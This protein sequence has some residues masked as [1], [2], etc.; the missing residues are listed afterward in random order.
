[1]DSE[2]VTVV[3]VETIENNIEIKK[4]N[5][6]IIDDIS[7]DS[8]FVTVVTVGENEKSL[9]ETVLVYR[10]P[11]ERLGFGL[12]FQGGTKTYE[13][14]ERLYI[15]SC[16]KDSPASNAIASWGN[17]KEGDEI[18]EIDS[19][20]VTK[21][22]RLECVKCLKEG[23]VAMKFIVRN[24]DFLFDEKTDEKI[25]RPA[26]P[27]VPPRKLNGN[28]KI[29]QHEVTVNKLK[30]EFTPPPEAEVYTNLFDENNFGDE[31][32]ETGSTIS[33]VTASTQITNENQQQLNNILKTFTQLEKEFTTESG[34]LTEKLNLVNK[35]YENVEIN[36][37]LESKLYENVEIVAGP[38]KP[39]PRQI[40]KIESK[41]E[42]IISNP[43]TNLN[44]NYK[45]IENWL[46]DQD[47]TD[48]IHECNVLIDENGNEF[49]DELDKT[50]IQLIN[51]E[52]DKNK[53]CDEISI[54]NPWN[55]ANFN[56]NSSDEGECEKGENLGPPEILD[57]PAPSE[58]YF[59]F[60]WSTSLL[61]TIG[62]V[63]EE[64]S[65]IEPNSG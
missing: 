41:L 14:V 10:L 39:K 61:P 18:L 52:S 21:M 27:P 5:D 36:N 54:N 47:T 1:M 6:K 60:H 19:V 23:S 63:E 25:K 7:P 26:P 4:S 43:S 17:L 35:N 64:F 49:E 22:T 30:E 33:N 55:C 65:S 58:A 38:P 29:I 15:Q 44:L 40:L 59:N 11:G 62:E 12:K 57:G 8:N 51:V 9:P 2:H 20:S 24:G 28:K 34:L 16:A 3:S 50:T 45:T 37:Q 48:N 13:K 42:P 56:Y 46:Q 31:S 53:I 32:D